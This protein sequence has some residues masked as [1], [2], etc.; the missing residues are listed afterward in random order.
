MT[1]AA[2]L[3]SLR[4]LGISLETDR[5]NLRYRARPDAMSPGLRAELRTNK[6]ALIEALQ[7]A[8]NT[9]RGPRTIFQD[10]RGGPVCIASAM[11]D[12]ERDD[13]RRWEGVDV[14]RAPP[15]EPIAAG[16]YHGSTQF[17]QPSPC[18]GIA[19]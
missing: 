2:L 13:A 19:A 8:G 5:E 17:G 11:H 14:A 12:Q 18:R 7:A 6:E 9:Q 1:V 10:G 3:R 16:P 15:I 4:D